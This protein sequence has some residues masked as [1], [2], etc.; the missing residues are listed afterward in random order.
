MKIYCKTSGCQFEFYRLW[1]ENRSKI[2]KFSISIRFKGEH[3]LDVSTNGS[4]FLNHARSPLAQMF[5]RAIVRWNI[6]VWIAGVSSTRS[7]ITFLPLA[8]AN[9]RDRYRCYLFSVGFEYKS[10]IYVETSL[11]HIPARNYFLF[12]PNARYQLEID[13]NKSL[14]M[15]NWISLISR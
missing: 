6:F 11:G 5:Y 7:E 9:A 13:R 15:F 2:C 14:R 3:R 8:F 12:F 10:V 1:M 4:S